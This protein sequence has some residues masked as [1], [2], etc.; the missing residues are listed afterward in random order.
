M[1]TSLSYSP[2]SH[3]KFLCLK[4]WHDSPVHNTGFARNLKHHCYLVDN[5]RNTQIRKTNKKTP[6]QNLTFVSWFFWQILWFAVLLC[7]LAKSHNPWL[8]LSTVRFLLLSS[9]FLLVVGPSVKA[10]PQ[11]QNARFSFPPFLLRFFMF[12]LSFFSLSVLPFQCLNFFIWNLHLLQILVPWQSYMDQQHPV[13][14]MS[15]LPSLTTCVVKGRASQMRKAVDPP[16]VGCGLEAL[17][18]GRNILW[19]IL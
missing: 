3:S 19:S 18:A 10:L 7:G 13:S 6:P 15:H 16:S 17:L 1:S 5:T 2:D 9:P 11:L 4:S 12:L 14:G 8:V